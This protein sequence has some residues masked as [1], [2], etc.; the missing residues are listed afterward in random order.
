MN[1]LS[2]FKALSDLGDRE[3][4]KRPLY[5]VAL[6]Q[7]LNNAN[8]MQVN[9]R[10]K[11]GQDMQM[12][13]IFDTDLKT[14][15]DTYPFFKEG[16]IVIFNITKNILK[17]GEFLNALKVIEENHEDF[18]LDEVATFGAQNPNKCYEYI[19]SAVEQ[20]SNTRKDLS[21]E[22]L[23][24]LVKDIYLEK[25]EE[26]IRSS[27]AMYNHHMGLGGNILHTAEVVNLLEKLLGSTLGKELD[28]EI[29][30]AAAALHDVGK[31]TCYLT[32]G[33]GDA[34]M[35][36]EGYTFG[37]HHYHSLLAIDKAAENGNYD[38]ERIMLLQNAIASHHGSRSM[39]DLADPISLE[40]YWLHAMDD[41][42]AKHFMA[43]EEI[44]TLAPGSFSSQKNKALE[45]RLYRRTDQIFNPDN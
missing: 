33:V 41:L 14:M 27:S 32:N 31:V 43:R 13:T 12:V 5:I 26:L 6:S 16:E 35:T 37:G 17:N 42:S 25:K 30:I 18:D 34:S 28:K 39:G 38:K 8:K 23:S 7:K 3:S 36:A 2:M 15:Q 9:M 44:K 4:I 1:K 10:V 40:A 11:D 21:H 22:P 45:T 24:N 29:V 19:I 20:A